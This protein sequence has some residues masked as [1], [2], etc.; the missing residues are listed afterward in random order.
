MKVLILDFPQKNIF[1]QFQFSNHNHSRKYSH[2]FDQPKISNMHKKRTQFLLYLLL[3][4]NCRNSRY[5]SNI[6]WAIVIISIINIQYKYRKKN[7]NLF[8]RVGVDNPSPTI[9]A[10][11]A[12]GTNCDTDF[13]MVLNYK[14]KLCF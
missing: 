5:C 7:S 12:T 11:A 14:L 4:R 2:S 10:N 1:M 9:V 8:F 3:T 6:L 13:L